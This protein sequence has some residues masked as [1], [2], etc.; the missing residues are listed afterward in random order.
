[1]DWL[2]E[3]IRDIKGNAKWD[4]VKWVGGIIKDCWIPMLTTIAAVCLWF[5]HLSVPT[6]ILVLTP[7]LAWLVQTVAWLVRVA[8]L[9]PSVNIRV[10]PTSGP[11]TTIFLKVTNLDKST[12]F[13]AFGEIVGH[14][15][16][17]ND[18]RRGEFQFGWDDG[19]L[20]RRLIHRDETASV[21][22]ASFEEVGKYLN[23]L[24]VW[25]VVGPE[26]VPW[27]SF[28]WNVYPQEIL[29]A[30][31]MRVRIVGENTH[32]PKTFSFTVRP[33]EF[34]GPL[35]LLEQADAL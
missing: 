31:E 9:S 7:I 18:F 32:S 5:T 6:K 20:E 1:M 29:P 28:R 16:G 12:T 3:Q 22:I 4:A 17:V 2:K 21:V 10:H 25:E 23:E 30:F 19:K 34:M 11:A 24:K 35:E 13:S 15:N 14:P 27:E 8:S 26:C 33:K